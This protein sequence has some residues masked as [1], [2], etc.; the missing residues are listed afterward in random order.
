MHQQRRNRIFYN[1]LKDFEII[2]FPITKLQIYK[3]LKKINNTILENK[4]RY[5]FKKKHPIFIICH[6]FKRELRCYLNKQVS[7]ILFKDNN[8]ICTSYCFYFLFL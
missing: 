1:H 6:L 5:F 8:L 7:H 2:Y 3:L 4:V